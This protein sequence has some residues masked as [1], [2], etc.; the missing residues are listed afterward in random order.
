MTD[1][2]PERRRR[3]VALGQLH[4]QW[5]REQEA[6]AAAAFDSSARPAGSDYNQHHVDV[7]AAG[8]AEDAFHARARR[9][10]NIDG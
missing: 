1:M 2:D 7:D 8:A 6:A 3:L 9:I 5:S 4:D 10:M